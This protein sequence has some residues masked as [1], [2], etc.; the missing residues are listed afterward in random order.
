MS[1]ADVFSLTLHLGYGLLFPMGC[2]SCSADLELVLRQ[3]E[4]ERMSV[5]VCVCVCVLFYLHFSTVV[6]KH[7]YIFTCTYH[8]VLYNL[9]N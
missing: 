6:F 7:W 9:S 8:S 2:S 4:R 3:R 5:F 1:R